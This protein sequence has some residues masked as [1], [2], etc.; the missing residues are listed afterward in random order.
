[1]NGYTNFESWLCPACSK[2]LYLE[3]KITS[4]SELRTWITDI[5]EVCAKIKAKKTLKKGNQLLKALPAS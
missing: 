5:L 2:K 1:M 3:L 4:S